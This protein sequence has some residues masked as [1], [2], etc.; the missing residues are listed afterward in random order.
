RVLERDSAS[1]AETGEFLHKSL[2]ALTPGC[3]ASVAFAALDVALW[4]LRSKRAGMP[5][6]K[7]L[8]GAHSRVQIYNTHVGWLNRP[9]TEML[10]LC[11]E[12]VAH[13]KFQAIKLKVGKPDMEE[14]RERVSKVREVVGRHV[15]LMVDANQSW[16]L[17]EAIKRI[18][19]LEPYDL[20]W[21]EEPLPAEQLNNF[22][23]LAREVNVA[24]AGGESIYTLQEFF[25]Y[26]HCNALG[27]MQPDVARIGGITEAMKVCA[28]AQCAGLKVAPHVSP[29]L[30]VSVGCAASNAEFIEYIPQMEK[31]L[32]EKT[33]IEE[34]FAYPFDRN[35]H[36][37]LFDEEALEKMEVADEDSQPA[38]NAA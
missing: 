26:A 11:K 31:V 16:T 32:L 4:D 1:I 22:E 10:S 28:L 35:G 24:L 14:D 17:H 9:L 27:Y 15:K 25:Q 7:M 30:S 36:G 20:V 29:E 13:G 12:A 18:K 6:Y 38:A 2:H 37:I 5:L 19:L 21:V 8:G 3:M 23:R 33:I 34:G